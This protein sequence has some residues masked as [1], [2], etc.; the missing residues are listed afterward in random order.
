MYGYDLKNLLNLGIPVLIYNGDQDFICNWR[1]GEMWTNALVWDYQDEF[2]KEHYSNWA[3]RFQ[4][5]LDIGQLK[6]AGQFKNYKNFTFLRFYNA[7]HMVAMD[8][9][10]NAQQMINQF[11]TTG[12]LEIAPHYEKPE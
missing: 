12:K 2:N 11:I 4:M 5:G 9:P 1:G 7:G 6:M 8:Q 3:D 10:A